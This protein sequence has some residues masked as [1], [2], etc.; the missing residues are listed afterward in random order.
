MRNFGEQ[1]SAIGTKLKDTAGSAFTLVQAV[2][3]SDDPVTA[4]KTVGDTFA[5]AR[6][7]LQ[8]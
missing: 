4:F 8:L 1:L 6:A 3:T 7:I 2:F 5:S